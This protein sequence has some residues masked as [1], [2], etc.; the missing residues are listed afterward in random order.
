MVG[1]NER[2]K[3]VFAAPEIKIYVFGNGIATEQAD[4]SGGTTPQDGINSHQKIL[5]KAFSEG[6]M[7]K[8]VT[9]LKWNE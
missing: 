8:V 3:Q 7:N 4:V 5:N 1:T 9:V 2:G 6:H